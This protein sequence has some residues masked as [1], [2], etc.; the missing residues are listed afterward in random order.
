MSVLQIMQQPYATQA[1]EQAP[2]A[3]AR[4]FADATPSPTSR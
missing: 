4:R 2:Q 3:V 1:R